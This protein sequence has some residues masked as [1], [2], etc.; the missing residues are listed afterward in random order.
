MIPAPS[1]EAWVGWW[2]DAWQGAH[3]SWQLRF[4]EQS[5]LTLSVCEALVRR[6]PEVFMDF[7]G[8]TMPQP[9]VPEA[10]TLRWLALEPLQRHLA[11]ALAEQI[12]APAPSGLDPS[13]E[14][15]PWCRSVAKALRPGLWLEHVDP[16][17]QLGIWLLGTWIGPHCWARLRLSW[18]VLLLADAAGRDVISTVSLPGKLQTLW[19]AVLWRVG[20]SK[21]HNP[22]VSDAG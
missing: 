19:S 6:R 13:D 18:P 11:L 10:N 5:G 21:H 22:E 16:E 8:M 4:A 7:A 3:A 20:R 14:Y 12:C 2:C 9:P 15:A 17:G 1:T